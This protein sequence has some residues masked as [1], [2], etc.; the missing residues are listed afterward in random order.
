[1]GIEGVKPKRPHD[2]LGI[3][4]QLDRETLENDPWA[5]KMLQ[6]IGTLLTKAASDQHNYMGSIAIHFCRTSGDL[7]TN[8]Y[9]IANIMQ[10][11]TG[12][13]NEAVLNAGLANLVTEF[14]RQMGR[15]H[16][17]TDKRDKRGE[18]NT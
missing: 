2:E 5:S 8:K 18:G 7:V 15:S 13:M 3:D 11:C 14:K 16:R 12:D 4:V 9:E 10:W 1:M 6:E 17:T